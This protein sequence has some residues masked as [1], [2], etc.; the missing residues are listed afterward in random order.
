MRS[1]LHN[2]FVPLFILLITTS[3]YGQNAFNK[4]FPFGYSSVPSDLIVNDDSSYTMISQFTSSSAISPG[5]LLS[6]FDK[7]GTLL[8]QKDHLSNST[9]GYY[10]YFKNKLVTSINKNSFLVLGAFFNSNNKTGILLTKINAQTLD[11]VWVKYYSDPTFS[12]PTSH[13]IKLSANRYWLIGNKFDDDTP[14][15]PARPIIFQTDTLGNISFQKEVT[16]MTNFSPDAVLYD[17]SAKHI[18]ITG[19][20]Y[21]IPAVPQ[22]YVASI[23]TSTSILWSKQIE[24]YPYVSSF[25]SLEKKNN[26]LVLSGSRALYSE[27]HINSTQ[28]TLLKI[29]SSTGNVIWR[30]LYGIKGKGHGLKGFTINNDESIVCSGS[31]TFSSFSLGINWN[32]IVMKTD[33]GG[34]ALW[35]KSFSTYTG[36]Y[37]ELLKDAHETLDK[38]YI[39]CGSPNGQG[40]HS[41]V[42]KTDSLGNAPGCIT[43]TLSTE[44]ITN[45]TAIHEASYSNKAILLYPNPVQEILHVVFSQDQHDKS[46]V[47]K[48]MS[49][50]VL[51]FVKP[52]ANSLN[53]DL[54]TDFLEN[55]VYI[56]TVQNSGGYKIIVSK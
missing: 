9:Q 6:K 3:C 7:A 4:N 35:M 36:S 37:Q 53:Y 47:I 54:P 34:E 12:L 15:Y 27:G 31:M 45:Y 40:T 19:L 41:W 55:G 39:F 30:K 17:S 48:D 42:I 29:N 10:F 22:S 32:G 21:N 56:V 44:D 38:G 43:S 52:E 16:S 5:L 50:R 14:G 2:Y 46:I 13:I 28:L 26:Y 25:F 33:A 1:N 23:D 11:T 8:L 49:G 51:K 20:N 24:A 18:Y